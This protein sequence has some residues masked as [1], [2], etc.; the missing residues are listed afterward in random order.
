MGL[1]EVL[2]GP[3]RHEVDAKLIS[4]PQGVLGDIL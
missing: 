4:L 1:L 3:L 2:E